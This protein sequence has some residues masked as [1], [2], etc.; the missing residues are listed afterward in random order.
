MTNNAIKER[1]LPVVGDEERYEVS[2]MGRV[3]R[4]PQW[5]RNGSTEYFREG[6][7]L[8]P[9]VD[10]HGYPCVDLRQRG[11]T[12]SKTV[13]RVRKVH[14]LVMEAFVG[15]RP[16]DMDTCHNNGDKLDSRLANL[17]YDTKSSNGFDTVR[18]G[19]N[20]WANKTHCPR[21]HE[22]TAENTYIGVRR[23]GPKTGHTFRTCRRCAIDRAAAHNSRKRE[24][25]LL[26]ETGKAFRDAKGG[27]LV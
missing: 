11:P 27:E 26:V 1:W 25:A 21:G 19:G 6:A 2:D 18:H 14:A 7:L 17:R 4:L 3:R 24:Q 8:K 15:P 12:G 20:Q 22:L 9:F 13:G 10:A 16:E 23:S 5:T